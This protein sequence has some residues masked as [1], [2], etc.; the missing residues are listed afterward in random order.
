[1]RE[2]TLPLYETYHLTSR[3]IEILTLIAIGKRNEEIAEKLFIS[4]H[5]VKT[6]LYNIF[7]KINVSDRLQAAF[8][9]AH[10]LKS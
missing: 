9:A 8:W 2:H 6:H 3:E 10:H 7:K 5:T 1:S 4:P